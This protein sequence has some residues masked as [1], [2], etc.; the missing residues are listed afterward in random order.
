MV[1]SIC[2]AVRL[3]YLYEPFFP[4]FEEVFF[5]NLIEDLFYVRIV[6]HTI[7]ISLRFGLLMIYHNSCSFLSFGFSPFSLFISSRFPYCVFQT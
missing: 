4:E 2:C 6:L 1:L 3:L 7:P 5:Y